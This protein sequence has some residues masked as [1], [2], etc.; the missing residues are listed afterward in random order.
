[1]RLCDCEIRRLAGWL[2][3]QRG[4]IALVAIRPL[5]VCGNVFSHS[6]GAHPCGRPCGQAQCSAPTAGD[7]ADLPG[8]SAALPTCGTPIRRAN[9]VS[10]GGRR[11]TK[12]AGWAGCST[13]PILLLPGQR[14]VV[15]RTTTRTYTNRR[16]YSPLELPF[17][18]TGK[19]VLKTGGPTSTLAKSAFSPE[20][21]KTVCGPT[22]AGAHSNVATPWSFVKAE[23]APSI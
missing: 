10:T 3:E 11:H 4:R 18:I 12:K 23:Y 13:P 16:T 15:L 1:M 6:V 20:M 7:L 22:V 21:A 5:C 2:Q 9:Q 17:S 8:R 14:M 19:S